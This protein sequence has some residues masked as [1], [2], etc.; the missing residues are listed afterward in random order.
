MDQKKEVRIFV[1]LLLLGIDIEI[2]NIRQAL[3]IHVL[4]PSIHPSEQQIKKS[5]FGL[6]PYV[7]SIFYIN[8]INLYLSI[9]YLYLYLYIYIYT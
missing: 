7:R 3:P 5:T 2:E 1:S 4:H 8:F 9:L 6:S